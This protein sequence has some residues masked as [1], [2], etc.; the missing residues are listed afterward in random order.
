MAILAILST[1]AGF[2]QLPKLFSETQGFDNYLAPIFGTANGLVAAPEHG[3]SIQT[4]WLIFILPL[5]AIALLVFYSY[6]RFVN[7][8]EMTPATGIEKVLA[9]KFYFD[10]I[11][12]FL[13]VKPIGFL[14]D[15]FRQAVDQTIINGF[16]NAIG[17]G[18]LFAGKRLRRLQ[19]GNV[20]FYLVIMV[21][22]VI[23][24]LFFNII[25]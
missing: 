23:A 12:D 4:E 17:N 1:I 6:H 21:F 15:F 16:V 9:D 18:T 25:L 5:C 2:V 14:S 19:T 20:G 24:I 7:A 22:S 11:Y 8:K 13:F 10:E 3:L